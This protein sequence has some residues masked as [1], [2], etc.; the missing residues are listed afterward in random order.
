MIL[1]AEPEPS[2]ERPVYAFRVVGF[3]RP[4]PRWWWE[5]VDTRTTWP[6]FRSTEFLTESDARDNARLLAVLMGTPS[7]CLEGWSRCFPSH[8]DPSPS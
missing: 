4:V 5:I 6:V 2:K 7:R 3:Q 8:R 1:P